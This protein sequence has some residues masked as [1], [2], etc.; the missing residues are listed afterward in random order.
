MRSSRA[1]RL[2]FLAAL[3]FLTLVAA[4]GGHGRRPCV[5]Q[6]AA[7]LGVRHA[8]GPRDS[9][10]RAEHRRRS[11]RAIRRARQW[12]ATSTRESRAR[13]LVRHLLARLP[14]GS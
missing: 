1:P 6:R 10:G 8:T 12:H 11:R 2:G 4:L 3:A 9:R 5:Y 14:P 13:L 7:R